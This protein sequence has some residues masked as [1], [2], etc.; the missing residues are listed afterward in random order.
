M[1]YAR[2]IIGG[3]IFMIGVLTLV[4]TMF[5]NMSALNDSPLQLLDFAKMPDVAVTV[6][7]EALITAAGVVILSTSKKSAQSPNTTSQ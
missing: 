1:A 6:I 7:L 3:F 2:M 4:R 5:E